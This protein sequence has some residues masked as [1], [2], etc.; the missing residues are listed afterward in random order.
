MKCLYCDAP[1]GKNQFKFCSQDHQFR[2]QE[3]LKLSKW[4][5]TGI[6]FV[7]SKPGHYIR[8]YIMTDQDRRCAVCAGLPEW[9]GQPLIFVLDHIDG[10]SENNA[11]GNLRLVCPNCDSQLPTF[12]SKNRGSGRHSRRQR[13]QEGKSY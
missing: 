2:Y 5:E 12:K 4:L 7:D 1:L 6:A 11:R 8:K 3:Q 13:Y 9:N 10:N